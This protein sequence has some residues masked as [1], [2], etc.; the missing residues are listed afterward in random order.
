MYTAQ[1]V[2]QGGRPPCTQILPRQGRPPNWANSIHQ[3]FLVSWHQKTRD[4]GL[5]DGEDRI[6]EC[7]GQMGRQTDM[8]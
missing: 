8:P 1:L 6:P 7:D 4:T 2:S 5:P 3:P